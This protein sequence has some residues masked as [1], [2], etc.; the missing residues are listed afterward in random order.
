MSKNDCNHRSGL[1]EFDVEEGLGMLKDGARSSLFLTTTFN[2]FRFTSSFFIPS[3]IFQHLPASFIL[4]SFFLSSGLIFHM[5][6]LHHLMKGSLAFFCLSFT[7]LSFHSS[8]IPF[9][10]RDLEDEE[11]QIQGHNLFIPLSKAHNSVFY[12]KMF[13]KNKN[14][15]MM[16]ASTGTKLSG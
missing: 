5:S 1:K 14:P 2:G 13:L 6:F 3:M 4:L 16:C 9:F 12:F 15:R 11:V 7:F 8:F 10:I